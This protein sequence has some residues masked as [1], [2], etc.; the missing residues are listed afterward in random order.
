MFATITMLLIIIIITP[1]TRSAPPTYGAANR[2][3][4]EQLAGVE[5]VQVP[6]Q[7]QQPTE[8]AMGESAS[9][10]IDRP[11]AS[12]QQP[13]TSTANTA[14]SGVEQFQMPQQQ[15]QQPAEPTTSTGNIAS[16][17]AGQDMFAMMNQF[18][19]FIQNQPKE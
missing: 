3:E 10:S 9:V 7:Q 11:L 2:I 6:Q 16:N 8:S 17:P 5:R 19:Q 13:S 14:S 1:T 12:S 4:N 15:Q 18:L